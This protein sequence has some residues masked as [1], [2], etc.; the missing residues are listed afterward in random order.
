MCNHDVLE[1]VRLRLASYKGPLPVILKMST[2]EW[3]A[4]V[5]TS[6]SAAYDE[7]LFK[8]IEQVTEKGAITL[9]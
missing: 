4:T 5:V 7:N 1:K 3:I 9:N 2:D 6:Y 8:E